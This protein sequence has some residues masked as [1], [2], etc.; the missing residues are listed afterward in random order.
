MNE[1]A[2]P[3]RASIIMLSDVVCP[4]CYVGL[5]E[6]EKLQEN[7]AVDI[8]WSPFLLD[9]TVPPEGRPQTPYNKPG[10]PPTPVAAPRAQARTM[11]ARR[12][13]SCDFA[14]DN[15][16]SGAEQRQS[17]DTALRLG[18]TWVWSPHP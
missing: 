9:P 17:L 15:G 13:G 12:L 3:E 10:D 16:A 18:M 6:L 11:A 5:A 1:E 14:R 7:F 2:R 4:W 8:H